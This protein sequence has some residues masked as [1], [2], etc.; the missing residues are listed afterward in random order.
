MHHQSTALGWPAMPALSSTITGMP[1]WAVAALTVTAL[2]LFALVTV[3]GVHRARG[4]VHTRVQKPPLRDAVRLA[5][6]YA[7]IG[8]AGMALSLHGLYGYATSMDGLHLSPLWALPAIAIFDGA[9]LAA[10]VALYR[11]ALTA[12]EWTR[13]MRRARR[14]A[15][16]L[17]GG[18]SVMN[19]LHAPGDSLPAMIFFGAVPLVSLKLIEFEL[20]AVLLRNDDESEDAATPGLLRL[21]TL[22]RER[23]WAHAFARL[24]FDPTG[25]GGAAMHAEARLQTAAARLVDLGRTQVAEADA[26]GRQGRG[27]ARGLARATAAREEAQERAER[28]IL[29]AGLAGDEGARVGLAR[30]MVTGGLVGDL[31]GVD[32]R[33]PAAVMGLLEQVAVL[34]SAE[35]LVSETRAAKAE[36][37]AAKAAADADAAQ[38][39]AEA[40]QVAVE[41]ARARVA[42]AEAARR[43]HADALADVEATEARR[44]ELRADVEALVE[45]HRRARVAARDA[46][47]EAATVRGTLAELRTDVD[48]ARQEQALVRGALDVARAE[49]EEAITAPAGE[50]APR[51]TSPAKLAGWELYRARVQATGAEPTDSEFADLP[52]E[53]RDPSTL[54]RWRTEFRRAI[55]RE[56]A[57]LLS[58]ADDAHARTPDRQPTLV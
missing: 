17:A 48:A 27:A 30:Y 55:A 54:R 43:V 25:R 35:A 4:G 24:G 39:R 31:A 45:E 1:L 20:D 19:A 28:A 29:M 6:P 15:W 21:L 42:E 13:E 23:A 57:A 14:L 40:A 9:E 51:W 41:A 22:A 56:A 11:A 16:C 47:A 36:A 53:E 38:A 26:K 44:A 58:G 34:P 49:V 3:R 10:F 5:G 37:R 33:S 32:R 52:G 50:A 46:Q 2:A 12:T 18:S 7:R 8:A